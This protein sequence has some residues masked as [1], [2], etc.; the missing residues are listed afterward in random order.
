MQPSNPGGAAVG[1][2]VMAAL[3][4]SLDGL[5]GEMRTDRDRRD[6]LSQL[7]TPFSVPKIAVPYGGAT[8][9]NGVGNAD[10]PNLLGPRTGQVWD[11]HQISTT[12]WTTGAMS[13]F[14]D[15]VDGTLVAYFTSAPA[16][17]NFGKGQLLVTA[18]SRLIAVGAVTGGATS[19]AAIAIRGVQMDA[20]VLADYLL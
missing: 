11:V 19:A 4:A 12:G 6:R 1:F 20:G 9:G 18:G 7:I 5:A 14:L 13:V 16:V 17:L 15:A 10:V 3:S 8:P 2:Q